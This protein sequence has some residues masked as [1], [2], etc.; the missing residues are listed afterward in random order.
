MNHFYKAT[1]DFVEKVQCRSCRSWQ[2]F[3]DAAH[4]FPRVNQKYSAD[5]NKIGSLKFQFLK[6]KVY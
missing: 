3:M 2:Y 4:F 6:M 1:I 5:L